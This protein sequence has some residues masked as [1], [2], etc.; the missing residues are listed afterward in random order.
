[1]RPREAGATTRALETINYVVRHFTHFCILKHP[2][3]RF[4]TEGRAVA[5]DLELLWHHGNRL[6][7]CPRRPLIF[8]IW[9][10]VRDSHSRLA[11]QD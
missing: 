2:S 8:F 3:N 4:R 5:L 6:W 11:V 9:Q 7:R 1:M 10:R